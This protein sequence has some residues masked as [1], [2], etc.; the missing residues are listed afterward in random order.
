MNLLISKARK[1][2]VMGA[3][4]GFC[5]GSGHGHHHHHRVKKSVR[6]ETSV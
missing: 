2:C 3:E 6:T 5:T 4:E 1:L